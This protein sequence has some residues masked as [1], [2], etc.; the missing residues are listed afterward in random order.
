MTQTLNIKYFYIQI[1]KKLI[2]S[3]A[4]LYHSRYQYLLF[5][6]NTDNISKNLAPAGLTPR[7]LTSRRGWHLAYNNVSD[8]ATNKL[9]AS[10]LAGSCNPLLRYT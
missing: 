6:A 8:C 7:Q 1:H 9:K 3:F 10:K 4:C 2:F 5:F